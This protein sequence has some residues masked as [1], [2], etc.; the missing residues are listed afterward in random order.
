MYCGWKQQEMRVEFLWTDVLAN[1]RIIEG[2]Y[3]EHAL[4]Y[5]NGRKVFYGVP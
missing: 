2:Q 4:D 3:Q 1:G 5:V